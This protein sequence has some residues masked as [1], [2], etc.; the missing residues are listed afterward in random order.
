MKVFV[1]GASGA[2][3]RAL[4]GRLLA[5]GHEVAGMTRSEAH[6]QA[7]AEQGV[8]P[9]VVDA[10]DAD[11]LRSALERL[12]PEVV[13]NQLTALP[14]T[15]TPEAMAAAG[16]LDGRLRREGGAN[17]LA[18]AQAAQV[19]RY[20]VQSTGFFYAP[21]GE[22][23]S[24]SLADERTAFAFDA[25]PAIAA[26][27]RTYADVEHH[28]FAAADL[29]GIAL[30]LGFLY[31]PG[32]WYDREK[33]MAERIRRQDFPI[34]GDGQGVWS[35]VHVEDAA[36][37]ALVALDHGQPGAYNIVDDDPSPQAV[38]LP[39]YARW[40]DAPPPPRLSLD[41]VD[42]PD[43]IYYATR[44]RGAS[45]AKAK[46]DLAWQPRRLIWLAPG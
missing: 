14:K 32:T 24:R 3:G 16:R 6:G 28:V 19:R 17:L 18:A 33:N 31:G 2:I 45:N 8:A 34:L 46:R 5:A 25:S 30:R 23:A 7:L 37:A 41:R 12:R 4:T 20:I 38:W 39:A 21:E 27:T 43:A 42:D 15:H 35:F 9:V 26:G 13:I 36:E 29:E 44:L 1:A 40:L 10:F 11:G 22:G